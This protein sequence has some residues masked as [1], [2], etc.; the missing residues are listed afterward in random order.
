MSVNAPIWMIKKQRLPEPDLP[1]LESDLF[2]GMRCC[3]LAP[4]SVLEANEVQP[5]QAY[6]EYRHVDWWGKSQGR[7]ENGAIFFFWMR[8]VP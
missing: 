4:G 6:P 8:L 3:F 7:G 2:T 1:V 5:A